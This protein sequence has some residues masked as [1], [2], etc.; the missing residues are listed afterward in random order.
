MSCPVSVH[1]MS[2][3]ST[4]FC[5][6]LSVLK[7]LMEGSPKKSV[8]KVIANSEGQG[9]GEFQPEKNTVILKNGRSVQYDQLV[10]A[11]G[12]RPENN[13]PGLDEAWADP[14]HPFYTSMDHPTWRT[15]V[16]KS[17]RFIHN[18]E[19]G[20]AIFYIPPYPFHTEI[21]NYNFFAAKAIW[22]RAAATGMISWANSRFTIVNAND[23]FCQF[24]ERGDSFIKSE[25]EKQK[26][27]VEYGL[28]LIEV[29]KDGRTAIFKNL[30][31]G[32]T[33]E[34]PYNSFYYMNEARPDEIISKAGLADQS[35]QLDVDPYTL[36]HKKYSNIFGLGD[37]NNV[38]TTKTFWGGF[39]QMH[40]V[41]HNLERQLNGLSPNAKYDGLS[42]ADLHIDNGKVV[43]L[44]HLY[45]GKPN[46]SLST[47]FMASLKYKLA[48]MHIKDYAKLLAFK[49]WGPPY[50]KWK[51]T[52]SGAG[53]A[54]KS[55][56]ELHPEKK[57]A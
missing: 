1:S 28:K 48:K 24:Y 13:I 16:T 27:N 49:N 17:Y 34:R 20:E 40:V 30:K 39:N 25:L 36:Q 6:I 3:D 57:Q 18:F 35:G 38:P 12:L 10:V 4:D 53:D 8:A 46:D 52:F 21:E 19:G 37:I 55:A 29:K 22:D 26:I 33:Q 44:S 41:R 42:E 7:Y 50:Y 56:V 45:G 47:G 2:R 54:P 23:T 5:V 32:E 51:K 43:K 14:L 9:V 31:T 15:T 11:T